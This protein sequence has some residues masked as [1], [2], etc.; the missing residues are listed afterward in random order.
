MEAATPTRLGAAIF[1]GKACLLALRRAAVDV[2][3]G[4]RQHPRGDPAEYPHLL[5]ES[6]SPLWAEDSEAERGL[7]LGKVENLRRALRRLNGTAVPAGE[8]LSFWKQ[9]GRAT[10]GRGYVEGRQLQEGCLVPAVGGGL[11]QLSNA[12]YDA[13]LLA[14]LEVVERHPHSRIIPGSAAER[15]RDATVAFNYIDLRVRASQRF[16]IEGFLTAEELVVRVRGRRPSQP[17][18]LT[19]LPVV[20]AR[21]AIDPQAHGCLTCEVE[22]CFRHAPSRA[23]RVEGRTAYLVD[24]SWPEHRRYV[25][26]AR[27]A[28]DILALPLDGALWRQPRYVWE[29]EGYHRVF[30]APWETLS[31][32]LVTRRLG[33]YGAARLRAQ[34]EG[35]EALARSLAVA[36]TPEVTRVCAAQSLLPFLW[37]EGHLGGR[38]L[39]VLMTRLPLRELHL[40]LDAALQRHPERR[41]LGEFRAPEWVVRAET[42]A[43]AAAERVVTPH[44]AVAALFPGRAALVPWEVP[45]P[46]PHQAG[47][48]VAFPGPTAAR[49]GAYELRDAARAL[50]LEIV[51]L[52]SELEGEG[53]WEGVRTRRPAPDEC[54]LDGVSAVVQPALI[55]EN[56]RRLL[57]ALAAGV[58]V[59]AT[60]ECGLGGALGATTVP[61]GD[62]QA[63]TDAL[64]AGGRSKDERAL[65]VTLT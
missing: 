18:L 40:R 30:S 65:E 59:I 42:E 8:V 28:E 2:R 27:T 34:L 43:L 6:R 3:A 55:E 41:T 10:R 51:L 29:T 52:G 32:A 61:Y 50:D 20:A 48:A 57:A 1:G 39:E 64:V 45:R 19:E 37:R 22:S 63:V 21:A 31:R 15:D 46:R 38:R 60:P 36:L 58:P 17:C 11:C 5:A 53:F 47:G 56:P 35:A 26:E 7:Q 62:T 16:L 49:K 4:V 23:P 54:W 25:R 24:E 12:L 9:V 13:A 44:A 14:G 33:R